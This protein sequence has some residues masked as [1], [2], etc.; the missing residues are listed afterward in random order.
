MTNI[1]IINGKVFVDGVES[2]S[3]NPVSKVIN[4]SI[5]FET[6]FEV[7]FGIGFLTGLLISLSLLTIKVD[8]SN[9]I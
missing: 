5:G 7:G 2:I 1:S 4:T 3:S 9:K 8:N 6:G